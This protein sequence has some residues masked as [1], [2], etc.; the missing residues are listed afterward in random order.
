MKDPVPHPP[1]LLV[2]DHL[3]LDFLN[4]TAVPAGERV[5]WLTDGPAL[6]AWLVGTGAVDAA[7]AARIGDPSRL[8]QVAAEARRLREWLRGFVT[9]RAGRPLGGDALA[10]LAP[11][12]ALLGRDDGFRRIEAAPDGGYR[13]RR[14]RR[15]GAPALVLQ[16]I[17]DA[18]GDLVC[19]A[20]FRLIHAC[21]GVGCTLMFLDRTKAH[22]RRWCSMA[23]CGNRAKAAAHR[24]RRRGL[25]A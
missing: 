4:S 1:P 9:A 14:E 11:L 6:L 25:E 3:A 23:V 16:P 19:G 22:V 18:I 10:A 12:N 5:E 2:G 24:A 20:D 15:W 7:E 13:W 8:D 17:A 21:E